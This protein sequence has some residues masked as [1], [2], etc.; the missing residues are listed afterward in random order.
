MNTR[1]LIFL[2][3]ILVLLAS[4][5]RP[6]AKFSH[7]EKPEAT[8]AM[9]F[10]NQS[11]KANRYEWDFGDGNT[12]T[13]ESPNH[14]YAVPGTYAV[15]L[16]AFNEKDKVKEQL[17]DLEVKKPTVVFVEIETDFG[18]MKL[19]L[20][21]STPKH[22]D[23]FIKLTKAGFYNDLLFHRV[24]NAFMIQGGDPNSKGAAANARLGSGGP[25]YQID[26]EIGAIHFKGALSAARTNN[27]QKRS[28]GSQ[29]YVVQGKKV[30]DKE[31]DQMELRKKMKYTDEQRKRYKEVGGTP[32]L[33]AEYTVYGEVVE[34]LEVIDKI[35]AVKTSKGDRPI[36]NVKMKIRIVNE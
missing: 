26:H 21:N 12:S 17:I 7:S 23:N 14:T 31:L 3:P 30:T 18:K 16:Q 22:R 33:D 15:K 8:K 32:F 24:I 13:E 10:Q 28:S 29:F 27:P 9:E 25:G 19:K 35:A 6:V 2:L 36:E 5:G 11:E 20:Y 34:G 4:C 1:N